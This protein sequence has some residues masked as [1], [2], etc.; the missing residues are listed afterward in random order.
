MRKAK[1]LTW[2]SGDSATC[3]KAFATLCKKKGHMWQCAYHPDVYIRPGKQCHTC[4]EK[5]AADENKESVAKEQEE[6]AEK[7]ERLNKWFKELP[8]RREDKPR[9]EKPGKEN[10]P[11]PAAYVVGGHQ[12]GA[13]DLDPDPIKTYHKKIRTRLTPNL[14][15]TPDNL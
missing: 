10:G 8:G 1:A 5:Q 3:K 12:G 6:Q 14:Q 13:G 11:V 7:E 9:K 15:A 4:L 2:A